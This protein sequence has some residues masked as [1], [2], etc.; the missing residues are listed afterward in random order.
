[1]YAKSNQLNSWQ[2]ILYSR[3]VAGSRKVQLRTGVS[4]RTYMYVQPFDYQN[5][6][7]YSVPGSNN[8]KPTEYQK[9][10]N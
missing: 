7:S 3:D 4:Q 6:C 8:G 5:T 1:M 10:N 2:F 9:I